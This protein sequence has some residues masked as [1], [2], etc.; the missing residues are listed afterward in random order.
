[1]FKFLA[2]IKELKRDVKEIFDE[3]NED[4]AFSGFFSRRRT[5]S[6]RVDDLTNIVDKLLGHLKLEAN[7]SDTI[8]EQTIPE[9]PAKWSIVP[10]GTHAKK[11]ADAEKA[12]KKTTKKGKK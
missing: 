11:V 5:L 12:S 1:M 6:K 8:P 9:V 2:D 7:E 4:Y 3:F 10:K